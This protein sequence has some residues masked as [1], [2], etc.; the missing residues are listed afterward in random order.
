MCQLNHTLQLRAS[1]RKLQLL[2][3]LSYSLSTSKNVVH[4]LLLYEV[5]NFITI[6]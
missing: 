2:M 6:L 4:K 3:A 1:T 5:Y